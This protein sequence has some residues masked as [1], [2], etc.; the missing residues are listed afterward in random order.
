MNAHSDL[1]G[2]GLYTL[3]EA[4]A[5]TG[6]QTAAIRRWAFGY[7]SRSDGDVIQHPPVWMPQLSGYETRALGFLDLLEVRFV[8]AFKQHGVSLQAIRA[9]SRFAR[10][11][12]QSSHPFACKSFK[13]DGRSIFAEVIE[14]ERLEDDVLIDLVKRQYAFREVI[15]PSLYRGIQYG[16][17]GR[18]LSWRPGGSRHI[19][20]DPNRAFGKP[21][22]SESGVPT[23]V[24]YHSF[25]A[26]GDV[27]TVARI[28]EVKARA[29]R[30][31]IAFEE[32][33]ARDAVLH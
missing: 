31:A 19:I 22:D 1:I 13:T 2:V 28:Y 17:E 4:S 30:D 11:Y 24:I 6:I 29:V 18:P 10:E 15:S 16:E 8:A 25:L 27:E 12:F 5:L 32:R 33:L 7:E 9:A 3:P 14:K 26:E 23:E 21:I 20:L